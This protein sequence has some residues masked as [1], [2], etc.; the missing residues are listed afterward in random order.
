[1][2]A[3]FI[4][5]NLGHTYKYMC[6]RAHAHTHYVILTGFYFIIIIQHTTTC[7]RH[8]LFWCDILTQLCSSLP[9]ITSWSRTVIDV[10]FVKFI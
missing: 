2:D 3:K 5:G 8:I 9:V 10:A 7:G 1:M 4:E 6:A